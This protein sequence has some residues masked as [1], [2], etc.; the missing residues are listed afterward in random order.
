MSRI[1]YA[2]GSTLGGAFAPTIAA[3]LVRWTGTTASVNWCLAGMTLVGLLATLLLRD[4]NGI[5]LGPDT[6]APQAVSPSMEPGVRTVPGDR[7]W[8][9]D[10][11]VRRPAAVIS[12]GDP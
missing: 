10:Q 12:H 9:A 4:R 2:I 8:S 3:D 5:A 1:S 6:E 11:P 7:R